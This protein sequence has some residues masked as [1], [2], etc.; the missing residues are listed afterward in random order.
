[1][2]AVTLFKAASGLGL[3]TWGS[4]SLRTRRFVHT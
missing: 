2:P 1:M 3:V 4:L